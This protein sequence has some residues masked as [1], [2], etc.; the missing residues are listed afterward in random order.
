[1]VST[2]D[3]KTILMAIL[4]INDG[5]HF[6]NASESPMPQSEGEVGF[7][8]PQTPDGSFFLR[9]EELPQIQKNFE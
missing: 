1:M 3:L 6:F 8:R 2:S 9:Y 4:R 5:K 7:R